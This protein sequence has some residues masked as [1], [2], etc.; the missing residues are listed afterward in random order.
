[1]SVTLKDLIHEFAPDSRPEQEQAERI[2]VAEE[3]YFI[4]GQVLTGN[5]DEQCQG[6]S[7][8][9]GPFPRLRGRN[10]GFTAEAV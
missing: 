2:G 5:S 9:Q 4:I 7:G 8:G 3:R 6:R 1:M 10:G